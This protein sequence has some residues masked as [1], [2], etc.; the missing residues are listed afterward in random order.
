MLT[1]QAR[2]YIGH[3]IISIDA[4][5]CHTCGT[6]YSSGWYPDLYIPVT[7]GRRSYTIVLYKCADC[8]KRYGV[9]ESLGL[10]VDERPSL[11]RR[12]VNRLKTK[13]RERRAMKWDTRSTSGCRRQGP[14]DI[15][16]L[17]GGTGLLTS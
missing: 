1:T 10:P 14:G 6:E 12:K 17:G 3:S 4:G 16:G 5:K 2:L 13:W 8:A 9:Q 11:L 15:L 7:I